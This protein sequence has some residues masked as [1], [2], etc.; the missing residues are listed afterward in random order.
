MIILTI[1]YHHRD[2][3]Q[4]ADMCRLIADIEPARREDVR[5]RLVARGDTEHLE[6]ETIR[7][8]G[9][10]FDVS[11]SKTECT[12]D[13]WPSGPNMMAKEILMTSPS[14]LHEAGWSD[15]VGIYLMEPDCVPLCRDW[16]NQ[17][18]RAWDLALI[19]GAWLMGS[20]RNSGGEHGHINGNCVIDPKHAVSIGRHINQ[21]IAWDCG[22]VGHVRNHW[23]VSGLFLN[24]FQTTNATEEQLRTPE[25]GAVPPVVV[26]G[27]KDNSAEA[28][29]RRWMNL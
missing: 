4:A 9:R 15:A 13:G 12:N 22:I 29:A 19:D 25:T 28:I 2:R 18:I 7:A 20:W 6:L 16:L 14:W 10:R 11:W 3:Q 26:H 23:C 8:I 27:V 1:P 21:H 17:I 5:V 24:R